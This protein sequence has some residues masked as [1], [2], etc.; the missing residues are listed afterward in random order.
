LTASSSKFS[1]GSSERAET[2]ALEEIVGKYRI[3]ATL[4]IDVSQ[5]GRRPA[6]VDKARRELAAVLKEPSTTYF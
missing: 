2:G 5:N 4:E 3:S 1:G 6:D